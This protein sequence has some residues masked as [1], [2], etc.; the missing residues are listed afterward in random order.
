M[1][2]VIL[3]LFKT[4]S[5]TVALEPNTGAHTE[6]LLE[7][8]LRYK[9]TL[10]YLNEPHHFLFLLYFSLKNFIRCNMSM[11]QVKRNED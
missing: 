5:A 10:S 2:R 7:G 11:D 6:S 1:R 4:I 8:S 3:A 9:G